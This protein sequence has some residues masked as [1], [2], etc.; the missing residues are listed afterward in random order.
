LARVRLRL[1]RFAAP[2]RYL[3]LDL[4]RQAAAPRAPLI[5]LSESIVRQ[6][7]LPRS[8][9][10]IPNTTIIGTGKHVPREIGAIPALNV[11][12]EDIDGP[13]QFESRLEIRPRRSSLGVAMTS[14]AGKT[15]T[16]GFAVPLVAG[17]QGG[18]AGVVAWRP[19][20]GGNAGGFSNCKSRAQLLRAA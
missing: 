8:W 17:Q 6:P 18:S 3:R 7:G 19:G 20:G 10:R 9:D 11:R 4:R 16:S 12:R 13:Y 1:R 5:E 14:P 2:S 15:A